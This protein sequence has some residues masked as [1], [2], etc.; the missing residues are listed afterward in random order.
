MIKGISRSA[1]GTLMLLL[2]PGAFLLVFFVVPL[3]AS[4][5]ASVGFPD[6][7]FAS[8]QHLFNTPVYQS[9][10]WKTLR[11]ALIVTL[12]CVFVGYP[13]AYYIASL[14]PKARSIAI[15]LIAMPF[16]LSVL[17]RNYVWML[18]LQNTGLVNRLLMELG[19]LDSPLQLMYNSFAVTIAMVNMLLPYM[20]LPVLSALLAVPGDLGSASTSLGANGWRT[21]MRVTLP[22]T[23]PGIAVGALLTFIVSLGFYITP[24]M[25][26]GTREMMVATLIA[27]NVREVLNWPLAFSLSTTLLASTIVLYMMYRAL[28]PQSTVMKAV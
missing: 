19:W 21:F 14:R 10:Y 5:G 22:L 6:V 11:I 2:V 15:I 1:L 18:A 7:S 12:I 27:F 8:Y 4:I 28:L 20:I 26:G 9:V 13:C 25:L 24:A 3:A 16:M 17:V 23:M